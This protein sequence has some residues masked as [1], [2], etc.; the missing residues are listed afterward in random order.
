MFCTDK[1]RPGGFRGFYGRGASAAAEQTS[2]A[3]PYLDGED[4]DGHV[5][6]HH[7]ALPDAAE[8]APGL[9]LQQLQGLEA[10]QGGGRRRSRV[11]EETHRTLTV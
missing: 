5:F 11:L 9:H 2:G 1:R 7:L 6:V 8:A 10:Q 4:L 3:L